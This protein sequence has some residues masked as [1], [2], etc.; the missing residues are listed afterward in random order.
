[1][2]QEEILDSFYAPNEGDPLTVAKNALLSMRN[3]YRE[4]GAE[5][6]ILAAGTTGY[7]EM[8]FAKAFSTESHTVETGLLTQE[9]QKNM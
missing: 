4:A 2:R 9:Q 1:M 7:G 5:L 8:L 6:H 3:R